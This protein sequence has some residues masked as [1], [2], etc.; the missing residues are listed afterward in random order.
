M[1]KSDPTQDP[2]DVVE[3]ICGLSLRLRRAV[4][5]RYK[6]PRNWGHWLE[7][8]LPTP[9]GS[10]VLQGYRPP[11]DPTAVRNLR[12]SW[13]IIV[14]KTNLDEFG[15]GIVNTTEGSAYKLEAAHDREKELLREITD[16]QLRLIHAQ[17]ELQKYKTENAQATA[18]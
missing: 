18:L 6:N 15:F 5:P 10:R 11:F 7:F 8:W 13:A 14:G 2:D 9:A 17:G 16:L 1:T 4:K 12:E 3:E